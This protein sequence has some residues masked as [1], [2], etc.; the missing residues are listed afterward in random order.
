MAQK[1]LHQLTKQKP[2][3]IFSSNFTD[4]RLDDIPNKPDEPFVITPKLVQE[5][6]QELNSGKTPGPDGWPPVFL[7]NVSDL[8]TV[9]ILFQKSLCECIVSSQWLEACVTAI[10]KKGK[11]NIF[12]NYR[13]ISITSIICKLMESIIRD[14]IVTHIHRNNLLSQHQHGFVPLRNC[15]LLQCLRLFLYVEPPSLRLFF[16]FFVSLVE[17]E[18]VL[19]VAV[20][21]W[22]S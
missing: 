3:Y 7:K 19:Q 6:I 21:W 12:E 2:L 22:M 14:K 16:P 9:P 13:P 18:M 11:K 15:V 4:E 5:K 20:L 10:H 17:V 8:I 1:Q